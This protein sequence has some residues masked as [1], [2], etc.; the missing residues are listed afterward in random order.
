[1]ADIILNNIGPHGWS[2][3]VSSPI[4]DASSVFSVHAVL[5]R[6]TAGQDIV[7]TWMQRVDVA[8][9]SHVSLTE[10]TAQGAKNTI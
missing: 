3:P 1:M 8:R 9:L 7:V 6:E 10:A 5:V 4:F 2:L